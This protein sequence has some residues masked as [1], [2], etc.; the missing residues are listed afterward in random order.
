MRVNFNLKRQIK[1]KNKNIQYINFY[2]QISLPQL[3]V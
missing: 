1:D 2:K 3:I